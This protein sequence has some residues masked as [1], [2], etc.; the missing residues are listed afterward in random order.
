MDE[1]YKEKIRD[2]ETKLNRG[3]PIKP[4]DVKDLLSIVHGLQLELRGADILAMKIDI[5]IRRRVLGERSAIA[6]ARLNY[7]MPWEYKHLTE[8]QLQRHKDRSQELR[9]VLSERE[10]TYGSS[11]KS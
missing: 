9:E 10:K 8:K 7:G 2:I 3:N 6:D 1:N 5:M 11:K 4:E